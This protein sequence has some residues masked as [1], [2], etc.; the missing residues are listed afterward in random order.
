VEKNKNAIKRGVV[1]VVVV[2]EWPRKG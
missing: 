2:R 1:V